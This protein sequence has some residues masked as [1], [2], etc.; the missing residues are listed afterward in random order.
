M[1]HNK[2]IFF[3]G[4]NVSSYSDT[5]YEIN[6]DLVDP[7]DELLKGIIESIIKRKK[8]IF[9]EKMNI[10]NSPISRTRHRSNIGEYS[11][12]L[13]LRTRWGPLNLI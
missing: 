3:S 6:L 12:R 9:Y 5:F 13:D 2:I 7:S 11:A 10:S 1:F 4:T 8:N